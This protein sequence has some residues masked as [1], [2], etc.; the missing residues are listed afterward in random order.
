MLTE[1]TLKNRLNRVSPGAKH[2]GDVLEDLITNYNALQADFA[3]LKTKYVALLGHLDAANVAGIGN[4]NATAY[5]PAVTT[6]VTI[7]KL[8][9]R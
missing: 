7:K 3:A 6:A 9:Q 4:G 5:T 8:S 2:L 1:T